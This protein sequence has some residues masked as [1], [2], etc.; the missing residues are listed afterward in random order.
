MSTELTNVI[1]ITLAIATF[2]SS[3]FKPTDPKANAIW[4]EKNKKLA[5]KAL[6][7]IT[8]ASYLYFFVAEAVSQEPLTR[9][10]VARMVL[11]G[12]VMS[13]LISVWFMGRIHDLIG[14]M[15]SILEKM[16]DKP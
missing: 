11:L 10:S 4:I 12:S 6:F 3:T 2:W 14:S 16:I 1:L 8:F 15:T 13:L 7:L 9:I 5:N